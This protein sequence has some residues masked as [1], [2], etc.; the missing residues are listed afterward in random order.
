MKKDVL[1]ICTHNAVRSQIAEAYLNAR[2]G[3]RYIA[4]SAGTEATAVHPLAVRVMAELGIDISTQRSKNIMEFFEQEMDIVVMVCDDTKAACPMY[5]WAKKT[6]HMSF[7]D[8]SPVVEGDMT[9]IEKFRKI[10]DDICSWIDT[11]FG[12]GGEGA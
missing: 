7:E 5:P 6:V 8:S 9:A 1:F 2:Y 4:Y 3:N 11:F 10:R 12:P